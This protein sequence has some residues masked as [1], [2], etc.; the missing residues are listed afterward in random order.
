MLCFVAVDHEISTER[1]LALTERH[2]IVYRGLGPKGVV[3]PA[4]AVPLEA[5]LAEAAWHRD[6]LAGPV[7][8][9]RYSALTF[10]D[11]RIHYDRAYVTGEE[12]CPGLIVHGPLQA[13][14]LLDL[15]ASA[16]GMPPREF[17]FRGMSPL[18]DFVP[19]RLCAKDAD[20]GLELWVETGD[21]TRKI[22]AGARW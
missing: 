13:T 20:A 12:G 5:P 21:G 15:S 18:F 1:G 22:A 3:P 17:S 16:R 7:L 8:L 6:T 11:H 9:F 2:D 10:N 14:L 4:V 19:F